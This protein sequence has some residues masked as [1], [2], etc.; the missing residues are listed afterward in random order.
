MS[1]LV[2]MSSP[3]SMWEGHGAPLSFPPRNPLICPCP[4]RMGQILAVSTELGG[5]RAHTQ[6]LGAWW[7]AGALD[8]G[9]LEFHL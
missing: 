5:L 3:R 8:M 1:G 2:N 7:F 4:W 9:G 6:S